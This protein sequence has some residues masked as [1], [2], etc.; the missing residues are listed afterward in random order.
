MVDSPLHLNAQQN[1]LASQ[2]YDLRITNLA[3]FLSKKMSKPGKLID[4]G[5]GNGLVLKFFKAKGFD[6][7][8]MELEEDLCSNMKRDQALKGD[9][10]I[11]VDITQVKGNEEYDYVLCSDVIEHIEDDRKAIDNLFTF[12]K[13]GGLLIIAVPAHQFLYGKRDVAWGHYRRYGK[14][15]L[16]NKVSVLN[17]AVEFVTFWNFVGFFA[18]FLFEKVLKKPIA[19][20]FRYNNKP[21]SKVMRKLLDTLL[22]IEE[23]VGYNPL[24]LTLAVGIRK[25]TK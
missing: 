23:V 17:G 15:E 24:G 12:V 3:R 5:A 21:S 1:E 18:Y 8:G 16:L 14:Q 25:A 7:S 20:G 22:R 9:T 2:G 19:E 10:I 11:Q 13:P 6:V 4:I